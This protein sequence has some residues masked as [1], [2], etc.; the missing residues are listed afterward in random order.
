MKAAII[1]IGTANYLNFLPKYWENIEKY[2]LTNTEKHIFAFTDGELEDIPENV[3]VIPQEHLEWPF[4]TLY[5]FKIINKIKEKLKDFDYLIFMDAD[6][7][8]VDNVSEDE[9]LSEKSFFS[10]HHP[11]HYMKMPP[12]DKL[13]GSFEINKNSQAFLDIQ[14]YKPN[15]YYQACFWGGKI[16]DVYELLD[17]LDSRIDIDVKNDTIPVWHDESHLNK[18]LVENSDRVKTLSPQFAYPEA[19]QSYCTFDPKIVHLKKDNSKYQV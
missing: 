1:F 16:P 2:F 6:T 8:V 12:H 17:V 13:P 7:L 5:R 3:T 11:C 9:I 19:F 14:K 4:I 15:I 10:V 18:F